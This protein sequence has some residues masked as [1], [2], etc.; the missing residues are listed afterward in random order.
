[1]RAW[2]FE[3]VLALTLVMPNCCR[4]FPD[5]RFYILKSFIVVNGL[6]CASKFSWQNH[7]SGDERQQEGLSPTKYKSGTSIK[8]KNSICKRGGIQLRDVLY[9]CAMNAI[10][11]NIAKVSIQFQ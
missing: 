11:T 7:W 8:G 5:Q 6:L 10:K 3:K 1:M 2:G 4:W 9:M